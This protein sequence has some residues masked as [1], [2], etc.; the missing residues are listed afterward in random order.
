MGLII[1]L[2]II[3][4]LV[5]ILLL[6][7]M[8]VYAK[9][10]L[11]P[12]G[13]VTIIVNEEKE[14]VVNPG[15][16]LLAT[17]AQEKLYLPSACGGGGTCGL[18]RCQIDSGGGSILPTEVGFFTRRQINDNWRLGCQVK[19]REDMKIRVPEEVLGI[20]KWECEVVSNHNV[21][22]FIKEFVVK[23]PPEEEL[24]F[25]S[26]GYIQIDVPPY[27]MSYR[28]IEVEEQF[29][30]EWDKYKMWDLKMKNSEET[31][32]AYS[33][34]NHPAEGNIIKLNIRIAT[35]PWDNAK[36]AFMK[37]PPGICSSYIFSRKPGDKVTISGPFGEFFIRDT[38]R[39]M[40]YIGGGAGMAPLRSHI[41]HL[42]QTLKT[43]RNVSYWYGARSKREIF[44][45]EEFRKIEKKF[46]N[47]KFNIA[48]SEPK[49]ED[50][51]NGYTGFIHQVLYD[52]YLS[53]HEEPEEVEYYLCGPPVMNDAVQCM[54]YNLGVPDEMIEFDDFGV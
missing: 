38:N 23:L 13:K 15:S 44:Y 24:H 48:L 39:E 3:V 40:V 8:L 37:V 45:E 51:W 26:G 9:E 29:R 28:D 52:E 47:F 46:P 53:H 10:K 25:K 36:E 12:K 32:R 31:F 4:F 33:M 5:I 27:E 6:V 41:F 35:P 34:A 20:K 21:A 16:T 42:F 18:C 14:L 43:S 19:V 2:S 7:T 50:N 22:T 17:L 11:T 49:P 1:L 30:D 54:L